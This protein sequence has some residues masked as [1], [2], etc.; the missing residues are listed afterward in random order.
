[1]MEKITSYLLFL[2]VLTIIGEAIYSYK[3]QKDL[4]WGNLPFFILDPTAPHGV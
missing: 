3:K 2:I 4:Y 1:M